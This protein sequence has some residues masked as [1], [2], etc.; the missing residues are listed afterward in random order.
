VE[1]V[2]IHEKGNAVIRFQPTDQP[3]L[4]VHLYYQWLPLYAPPE[5]RYLVIVGVSQ[6]SV[7]TA[8]PTWV[9]IGQWVS[10]GI[11][12]L[13]SSAC[14]LLLTRLGYIYTRRVG[15]PYRKEPEEG[16]SYE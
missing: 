8:I 15:D 13:I 6:L 10:G 3:I 9:S 4:E 7:D 16:D 1:A 12:F 2:R 11:M 5:E 14:I